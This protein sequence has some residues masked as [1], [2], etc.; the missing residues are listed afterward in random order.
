M[1]P[2]VGQLLLLYTVQEPCS[3]CRNILQYHLLQ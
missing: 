3:K 2:L 1:F